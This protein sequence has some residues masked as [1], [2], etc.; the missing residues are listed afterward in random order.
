MKRIIVATGNPGKMKEFREILADLPIE[1]HSLIDHWNP[2]PVIEETGLTFYE[3]ARIKADWVFEKTGT[4]ALA[5]DSGLEVDALGAA[6]GV[7]SARYAGV[8]ANG[9]ENNR[10][11]LEM[12]RDVPEAQRT[13]RFRCVLVLRTGLRTYLTAEGVCDGTI[14]DTPRGIGGFGYDPLFIP[15]GYQMTFAELDSSEKNRISHRA[16]ALRAL[17]G[18]LHDLT[19]R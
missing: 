17:R 14:I 15:S 3:N 2:L 11:L 6:P 18:E 8:H 12:L 1:L 9:R 16:K 4:W 5:D 19:A 10:K 13:A 7:Q